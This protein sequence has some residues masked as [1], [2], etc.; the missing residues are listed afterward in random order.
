MAMTLP[1]FR[2]VCWT[3]SLRDHT[4]LFFVYVG[5][6]LYAGK[7][8]SWA[9]SPSKTTSLSHEDSGKICVHLTLPRPHLWDYP[10]Y[11]VGRESYE[12][13]EIEEGNPYNQTLVFLKNKNILFFF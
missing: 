1:F 9:E 4:S 2:D 5:R 7:Q 6:E 3:F 12:T 11:V 13:W 10:G 8:F